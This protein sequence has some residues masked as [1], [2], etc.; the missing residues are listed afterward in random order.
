M[1]V[2]GTIMYLGIYVLRDEQY[3]IEKKNI[4]NS[5]FWK[6]VFTYL[7]TTLWDAL[8]LAIFSIQNS[9]KSLFDF[10]DFLI[11]LFHLISFHQSGLR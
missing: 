7:F 5:W 6:W 8:K 11:D 10:T 9:H 1:S 3:K 2:K 4:D